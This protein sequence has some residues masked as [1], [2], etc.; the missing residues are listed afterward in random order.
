MSRVLSRCLSNKSALA[1]LMISLMAVLVH[2][3]AIPFLGYYHDDWY[4]LWS[5]ASRGAA[6]LVPLFSTDRPFMG[7]I[8]TSFYWLIG[9]NIAGWHWFALFFRTAGACAFYWILNLAW[10]KKNQ[11]LY[12][13][14]AMLF[15]VFPGFLAQPNAATKINHLMGYAAALFSIVFS[16]RAARQ[17]EPKLS[18]RD[19]SLALFLFLFYLL[20]YEYMIGLEVMRLSLLFWVLWQG[21]R[22]EFLAAARKILRAYIPYLGLLFVYLFWRVFIFDGTRGATDMGGLVRGYLADP[23]SMALRLI[24]QT[25]KDFFSA[26]LFAWF[27]QAYQY[28]NKASFAQAA[29]AFLLA[30]IAALLAVVT[31]RIT[32]RHAAAEEDNTGSAPMVI[33]GALITLGAVFPVVLS[34]RYLE[35][36]DVYKGYGLHPSAGVLILVLGLALSV[37]PKYRTWLLIALIAL[38]VT[39]QSLNVQRWA[40]FW[41]VQ[42]NFWWQV[43]WRAPDIASNTLVMAYTPDNYLLQQDYEAWGPL[44]LIYRTGR[45]P[46][47]LVQAEVLNPETSVELFKRSFLEPL[48]RDVYVPKYYSH[49][50]LFS[51]PSAS[52][53]VQAVD[54][55]MPVYSARERELVEKAGGYSDLSFIDTSAAPHT[56]PAAV[57]GPEPEHGWCYYYQQAALARQQGDWERIGRIYDSVKSAGLKAGD[58]VEYLVYIEGLVNAGREDEAAALTEAVIEPKSAAHFAICGGLTQEPN[59][60]A[61]YGYRAREIFL[62]VCENIDQ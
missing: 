44:N 19:T 47:P 10:P 48:V 59:F 39:T 53:C 34:N 50:L 29:L 16:L 13:V 58:M 12:V 24:L 52:A 11:S 9:D 37:R 62:L 32:G 56:P 25:I 61:S 6:S 21:R 8:Y 49:F 18:M 17:A 20:I 55:R 35:L 4:M 26:S 7:V 30:G 60:P 14:A 31:L 23:M 41:Q 45:E 42:R 22:G 3:L 28:L 1:V 15:V 57:F 5:G 46:W 54:G 2:G 43:T 33:T 51:Q 38:S 27:T 40:T 36:T